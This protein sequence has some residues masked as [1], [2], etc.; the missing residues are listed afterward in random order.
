[1]KPQEQQVD[2]FIVGAGFGGIGQAYALRNLGLSIKIIDSLPDLGGTWLTNTYPGALSDTESFVYRFSWDKEDLQTYPWNRRYL[3]QPE[4]L[5]YLRH[6]AKRHDLRKY[7]EF[8]VEMQSAVW[9]EESHVWEIKLSTGQTF[10]ARYFIPAMGS[11]SKPNLPD[12]PGISMFKGIAAHTSHW[13]NDLDMTNKRVGVLGCGASGVQIITKIAP[14]VESLTAFIRHPQYTL[15]NNDRMVTPEYRAWV[16]ENYDTIWKQLQNSLIG[17]GYVESN[18][19]LFSVDPARLQQLL[20]DL[21]NNGNGMR[22]MVE[23][24]CDITTNEK[25]NEVVCDFLRKKIYET[26][27]DPK[28]AAKLIPNEICARRPISN[29]GYYETYNRDNVSIVDLKETP[30]A[31]IIPEG[32]RTED[33]TVHKLDVLVLATGFDAVEGNLVRVN[34]VGRDGR[35]LKDVWAT[36]PKTY[37]GSFVAEF[38]NMFIVNGP[39]GAFGNVVPAVEASVEFITH[40]I[41]RAEEAR[42]RHGSHAIVEAT[43]E[44]ADEWDQ[45]CEDAAKGSLFNKLK[46]S[47][48]TGGNIPGKAVGVRAYFGGLGSYRAIGTSA[49][50]D[51]WKGF[52]PLF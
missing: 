44:S 52:E 32:V 22:F 42:E 29:D 23:H 40:A 33:G 37:L 34:I 51:T 7:M 28:K 10:R 21:W 36:G 38:P 1:M 18:R 17:F 19:P 4:I 5:E 14:Y 45:V 6:F 2:V 24:F 39:K 11:L 3:R 20:E 43:Q 49:T 35:E 26:V 31:E 25:A 48:F 30:I 27:K 47:W 13:P 12:I 46:T 9:K 15:P 50:K 41:Q 8:N 16:N